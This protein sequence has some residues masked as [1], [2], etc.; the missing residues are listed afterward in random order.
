MIRRA[1]LPG[2]LKGGNHFLELSALCVYSRQR[3]SKV[4]GL[5]ISRFKSCTLPSI[6]GISDNSLCKTPAGCARNKRLLRVKMCRSIC[7]VS[8]YLELCEKNA[9]I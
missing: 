1:L 8:G 5:W 4:I 3:E 9:E 7:P 6:A 2:I